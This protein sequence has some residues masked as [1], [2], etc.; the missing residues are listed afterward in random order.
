MPSLSQ[1]LNHRTVLE[2]GLNG[3]FMTLT[4]CLAFVV[5]A[6]LLGIGLEVGTQAWPAIQAFGGEFLLTGTW[7]P[8]KESYGIWPMIYGTLVSAL[9]ALLLAIPLG[10]GSAILLAEPIL[11]AW[12]RDALTLG[13]ELLAAVPSVVY[14]LWGIFILIPL[15]R[16]VGQGL[17]QQLGFI[18]LFSTAPIGPGLLPA[19]V[20]LAIMI[21]PI[22]TAISRQSLVTLPSDLRAVSVGLGA[23]RWQT[24]FKTLLPAAFP[25]ILGGIVL[26]LGRAVGETMAVTMVIG[27]SNQFNL[28]ILAPANTLASLIASQFAEASGLQISALMYAGL[29][30]FVLTLSI[31]VLA[32]WLVLSLNR[33]MH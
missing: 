3:A 21:L 32:D 9:M 4:G 33:A 19:G 1:P 23:T 31:N 29:V 14:G 12:L 11:P 25:G 27:N 22:I 13:V 16:Q 17:H 7:D 30:L 24:L 15:L 10:L 20:I 6:I 26:A 8:V 5:L 2:R 18:P 28:S